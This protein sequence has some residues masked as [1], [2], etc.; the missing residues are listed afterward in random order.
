M[1]IRAEE[2]RG[3]T[4]L[5]AAVRVHNVRLVRSALRDKELDIDATG[6]SGWTALH[7]AAS[8]GHR[9]VVLLL[10]ESGADPDIQ[11]SIQKCTPIHLAA[12]N[13][14]LEVV[15]SLARGGARLD[16]RNSLGKI[17]QDWADEQCREFLQ[18]ERVADVIRVTPSPI[19]DDSMVHKHC[20]LREEVITRKQSFTEIE[21]SQSPRRQSPQWS[22]CSQS[23]RE[24]IASRSLGS[25]E[26][27]GASSTLSMDLQQPGP[28]EM[29]FSLNFSRDRQT[30]II[31]IGDIKDV[32]LPAGMTELIIGKNQSKSV[33]NVRV[34]ARSRAW[35]MK[36]NN[37]GKRSGKQAGQNFM[38]T[39]KRGSRLSLKKKKDDSEVSSLEGS[40]VPFYRISTTIN[41]T[42]RYDSAN[43]RRV[44]FDISTVMLILCGRNRVTTQAQPIACLSIPFSA[45]DNY[46]ALDWYPLVYKMTLPQG[47]YV[48]E[49]QVMKP[50]NSQAQLG[51]KANRKSMAWNERP[52]MSMSM[53]NIESTS[54]SATS[55]TFPRS[56]L[57][58]DGGFATNEPR[59]YKKLSGP[60]KLIKR[61]LKLVKGKANLRYQNTATEVSG[62]QVRR[63]ETAVDDSE[64]TSRST[65]PPRSAHVRGDLNTTD[66][67]RKTRAL[68]RDGLN[69]SR[70]SRMSRTDMNSIDD[71]PEVVPLNEDPISRPE[72]EHRSS[73]ASSLKYSRA[74]QQKNAAQRRDVVLNDLEFEEFE[75]ELPEAPFAVSNSSVH[76][77]GIPCN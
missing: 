65:L 21:A 23:S 35:T 12:K 8:S 16:L 17:P 45:C 2:E 49:R 56:S 66:I 24:S 29:R 18:R 19:E 67:A 22:E 20:F 59:R 74:F 28:G 63:L 51:G 70:M 30:L 53:P 39:L 46:A 34:Q 52:I 55:H 60:K 9:D 62:D 64:S 42:F 40:M 33:N 73:F 11:D 61:E 44:N 38:S 7:E 48:E 26:S 1:T 36:T 57:G 25:S 10:L 72:L 41:E 6:A 3:E 4:K 14:H 54:S 37:H 47:H 77:T 32:K 68:P 50:S 58:G 27:F 31:H 15:R 5:H 71:A 76:K 69:E 75:A 13:G 43:L